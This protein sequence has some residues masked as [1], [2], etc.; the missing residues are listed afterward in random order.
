MPSISSLTKGPKLPFITPNMQ[1][2]N[3]ISTQKTTNKS[4]IGKMLSSGWGLLFLLL[5]FFAAVPVL[6]RCVLPVFEFLAL[7]DAAVRLLPF[8]AVATILPP[9]H[10]S[11]SLYQN[12]L[13][14]SYPLHQSAYQQALLQDQNPYPLL[15]AF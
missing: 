12:S 14:R 10:Q 11:V 2:H 4:T 6:L 5:L 9:Y 13:C 15:Y 3:T 8:P 7:E 1:R